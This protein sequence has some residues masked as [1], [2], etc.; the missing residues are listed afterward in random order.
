MLHKAMSGGPIKHNLSL[1]QPVTH[2]NSKLGMKK[3][4][5]PGLFL[6][7][8]V[9]L[10]NLVWIYLGQV[11]TA[12]VMQDSSPG[13]GPSWGATGA[14]HMHSNSSIRCLVLPERIC[15][16]VLYLSRPA[17]TFSAWRMSLAV[18]LLS[19][20][21]FANSELKTWKTGAAL[22]RSHS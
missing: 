7:G 18:F 16:R 17:R 15:L 21:A 3:W 22:A 1:F 6:Y 10:C 4:S 11:K 20:R 8:G 13:R 19:S 12:N 2:L 14:P 9:C 5:F